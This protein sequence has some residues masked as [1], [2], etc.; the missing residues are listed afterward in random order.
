MNWESNL[1]PVLESVRHAR[2]QWFARHLPLRSEASIAKVGVMADGGSTAQP[3]LPLDDKLWGSNSGARKLALLALLT[4]IL[5]GV[6]R[7]ALATRLDSF[8]IDEAYHT[9]AG[10]AYVGLGDLST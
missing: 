9:T 7:S 8:N 2:G 6:L 10:V 5:V 4:L 1:C 3:R